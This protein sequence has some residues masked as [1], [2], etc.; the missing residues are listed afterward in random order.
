MRSM[1][2]FGRGS[3][4]VGAGSVSIEIRALNHRHQD[5]RLRLPGELSEHGFFVEQLARKHLGRGR[6]DVAGR[7]EGTRGAER[8]VLDRARAV[9]QSLVELRDSL[10]PGTE[11]PISAVL[12][13]PG[14]LEIQ[15]PDGESVREGLES[16]FLAALG[17]LDRMRDAEGATLQ[18]ELRGRLGRARELVDKLSESSADLVASYRER[19]RE[20]LGKLLADSSAEL[21]GPRLEQEVALL[22][23]KSDITEE[24]V[25]LG[26]HFSQ[27]HELLSSTEPVGRRL[28]FLFQEM[29]R[30]ANTIGSKSQY[31]PLSHLV[32][33]LKA[34]LERMREQVQNVD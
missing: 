27:M 33:D 8:L 31:A 26:S 1:T 12:G 14:V 6:F 25:R 3:A 22:A 11:V 30:E 20:R 9:Y 5:V 16:A 32:V 24:L 13:V 7:S 28:D 23:D 4:R 19:L 29:G 21:S 15:G 18:A 2:G 17:E 10:A 34:E